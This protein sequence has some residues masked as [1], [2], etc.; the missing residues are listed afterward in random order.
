MYVFIQNLTITQSQPRKENDINET[1]QDFN[2]KGFEGKYE[3]RRLWRMPNFLPVCLQD[4]LYSRE[5]VLRKD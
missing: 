2:N 5:S 1:H 3:E 4:I